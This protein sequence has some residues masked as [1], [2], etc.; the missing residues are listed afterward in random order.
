MSPKIEFWVLHLLIATYLL[1][2]SGKRLHITR[3]YVGSLGSMSG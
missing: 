1:K 2:K 3:L